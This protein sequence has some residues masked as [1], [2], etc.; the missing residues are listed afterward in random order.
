M[1][2]AAI[3]KQKGCSVAMALLSFPFGLDRS[4]AVKNCR[5]KAKKRVYD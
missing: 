4:R 5:H 3:I 2:F 1:L